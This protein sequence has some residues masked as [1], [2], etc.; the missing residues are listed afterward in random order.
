M[1]SAGRY[2]ATSR[3]SAL[4]A[5]NHL[6]GRQEHPSHHDPF[7]LLD[8]RFHCRAWHP[9][10]FGPAVWLRLLAVAAPSFCSVPCLLAGWT[11]QEAEKSLALCK[12]C[13]AAAKSTRVLA[14]LFSRKESNNQHPWDSARPRHS[15]PG[16]IT[17][18][19]VLQSESSAVSGAPT[20]KEMK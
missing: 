7:L 18:T 8:T 5:R 14:P 11:A 1:P 6:L 4:S 9:G 17:T 19:K 16:Q 15:I 3:N 20:C 2:S 13:S 10:P 12:H